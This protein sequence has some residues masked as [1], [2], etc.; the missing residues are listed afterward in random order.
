MK[1]HRF[2]TRLTTMDE[3]EKEFFKEF[4]DKR[5]ELIVGENIGMGII[6]FIKWENTEDGIRKISEIKINLIKQWEK[7]GRNLNFL[8]GKQNWNMQELIHRKHFG[9]EQ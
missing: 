4:T 9:K 1:A 3:V 7:K 5:H 2:K 6:P 8:S